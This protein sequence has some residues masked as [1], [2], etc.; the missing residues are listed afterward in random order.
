MNPKDMASTAP[1]PGLRKGFSLGTHRTVSPE[2]TLRRMMPLMPVMGITRIAD[3]TGLDTI[4]IPVVMVTRPNARSLSVAQGKGLTL[5]AAKTSG[6]MEAIESHHAEQITLPVRYATYNELCF[7]HRMIDVPALPRYAS[8]SFHPNLRTLWIE[9]VDLFDGGPRLVP[10][11]MVH[12]DFTLPLPP[13]AG[14]F[15]TTS[16]GLSSG[17][18]PLE[19]ICHAVS[20]L[21]ERDAATLW[22]TK[23]AAWGNSTRLDLDTVDDPACRHILALYAAA[24]ISV[25]AWDITSDI[26]VAAFR[27]VILDRELKIERALGPMGGIGC[28][29]S[30]GI[31]LLRALTEA[32][33]SRL[34]MISGARDDLLVSRLKPDAYVQAYERF[35]ERRTAN[36]PRRRFTE[37]PTR[38]NDTFEADLTYMVEGLRRVDI[39]QV[40]VVNL[41]KSEFGIPVVRVVIPGLEVLYE[42]PGYV[43]GKR[44]RAAREEALS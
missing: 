3:V 43:P 15:M 12:T 17:N 33:Q 7:A 13:G 42:L 5:A 16:S 26:G 35:H 6:L 25:E 19:A 21:I 23:G 36:G 8:G 37:I 28:H 40:V 30:R 14:I 1:G 32:A 22:H 39:Q 31:A 2:E 44:A 4:G 38:E 11:A 27:A 18:H 24:D 29:P 34:T 41:T 10:H 9:G 20:E